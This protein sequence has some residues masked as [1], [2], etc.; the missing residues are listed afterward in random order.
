M[1][2]QILA[3]GG[4]RSYTHREPWT[5]PQRAGPVY[6][7]SEREKPARR[8]AANPAVLTTPDSTHTHNKN[9]RPE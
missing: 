1:S 3:V 7:Q 8:S 6:F 9:G 4:G 5:R 2:F